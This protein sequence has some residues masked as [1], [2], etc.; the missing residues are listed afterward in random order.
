MKTLLTQQQL[1]GRTVEK[2]TQRSSRLA[3]HLDG[4]T[5]AV[6]LALDNLG[7]LD[8]SWLDQSDVAALQLEL[9]KQA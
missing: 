8:E 5:E 2:V 7:A 1:V 9:D 3:L 6:V 4:G